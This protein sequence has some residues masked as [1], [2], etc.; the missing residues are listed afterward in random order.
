MIEKFW[1]GK[2]PVIGLLDGVIKV[3]VMIA[4]RISINQFLE[5]HPILSQ[6]L[7]SSHLRDEMADCGHELN[8]TIVQNF[9]GIHFSIEF[10]SNF[11]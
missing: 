5:T 7:I 4:K 10:F 6:H 8:N 2:Q 9:N 1:E 3:Q 11:E